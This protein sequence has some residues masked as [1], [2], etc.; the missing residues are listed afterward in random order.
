MLNSAQF[1]YL[2]VKIKRR[3]LSP[4]QEDAVGLYELDVWKD[5]A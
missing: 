2:Q 4:V 5:I 3:R 1:C